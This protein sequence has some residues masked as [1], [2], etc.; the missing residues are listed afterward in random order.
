MLLQPLLERIEYAEGIFHRS[1]TLHFLH[2]QIG[3]L[4]A[5]GDRCT[6]NIYLALSTQGLKVD[7]QGC[8]N[9]TGKL[10]QK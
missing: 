10:G 4:A 8:V 9:A 5:R 2:T 7:A 1:S 3:L 6:P